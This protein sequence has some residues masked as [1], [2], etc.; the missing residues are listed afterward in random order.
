M[1]STAASLDSSKTNCFVGN[2][3]L[4]VGQ[5]ID[6]KSATSKSV[7]IGKI[8]SFKLVDPKDMKSVWMNIAD[9]GRENDTEWVSVDV[10][11]EHYDNGLF[12]QLSK[13]SNEQQ[14]TKQPDAPSTKQ[15]DI[16]DYPF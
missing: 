9:M 3:T 11:K 10:W 1:N 12:S 14:Q 8:T 6:W 4:R 2:L 7:S 15:E 5:T 13:Q 16:E